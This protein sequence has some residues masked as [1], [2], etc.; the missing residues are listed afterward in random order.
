MRGYV[1]DIKTNDIIDHLDMHDTYYAECLPRIGET[2]MKGYGDNIK[3]KKW[4]R[5]LDVM[6][7]HGFINE[8]YVSVEEV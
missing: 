7:H 5:V 2:Y 6:Y 8:V 1:I 4:Y 3:K